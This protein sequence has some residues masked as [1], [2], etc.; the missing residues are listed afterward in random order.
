MRVWI[1]PKLLRNMFSTFTG[2]L[3]TQSLRLQH[4][5]LKSNN[6]WGHGNISGR[7][8]WEGLTLQ[9]ETEI[10]KVQM[11][12]GGAF[13][14][15]E[16]NMKTLGWT[17][18]VICSQFVN[19]PKNWSWVVGSINMVNGKWTSF[20]DLFYTTSSSCTI[21]SVF[22][23]YLRNL[24][25]SSATLKQSSVSRVFWT[26]PQFQLSAFDD[27]GIEGRSPDWCWSGFSGSGSL[28]KVSKSIRQGVTWGRGLGIQRESLV[29]RHPH[30]KS[31]L[32]HS[33]T[34]RNHDIW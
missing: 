22:H 31:G 4:F 15:P 23:W 18:S 26:L 14:V 5:N 27:L 28:I 7:E 1:R 30:P 33:P 17:Y 11:E 2:F 6:C 13:Q 8:Q 16:S 24:S 34:M 9:L 32:S 10:E 21:C 19:G 3:G 25:T 12:Q 29:P 20:E